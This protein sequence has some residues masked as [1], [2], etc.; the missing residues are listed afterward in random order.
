MLLNPDLW[1]MVIANEMKKPVH[2]KTAD[3]EDGNG[4]SDTYGAF[5]HTT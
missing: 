3:N 4:T 2:H 1:G 5:M